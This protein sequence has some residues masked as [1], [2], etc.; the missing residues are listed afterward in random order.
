MR[1]RDEE[2]LSAEAERD[3][4]ALDAALAGEPVPENEALADLA[5]ELR[6]E[7]PVPEPRFGAELD[8]RAA[9]G[10]RGAGPSG[11]VARLR[12]RISATPPRRLLAPAGALAT[13]AVVAGVALSQ[14]SFPDGGG[15]DEPAPLTVEP[16]EGPGDAAQQAP[17][18]G[19]DAESAGPQVAPS[20]ELA[21]PPQPPRPRASSP[22]RTTA[23]SSARPRSRS[24]PR[25]TRSPRSPTARSRSA[26]TTAGSS[27]P[28]RSARTPRAARPRASSSRS[29]RRASPTRSPTSRSS[30]TSPRA[31]RARST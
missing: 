21:E 24:R 17:A 1:L 29:R 5:R 4:A 3:L 23:R 14:T 11:A 10:F 30:P 9:E 22:A 15:G 31:A 8:A 2:T 7:R 27:S 6:A 28:R 12:E 25:R 19:A 26:T 13:L 18:A 16:T 20:A